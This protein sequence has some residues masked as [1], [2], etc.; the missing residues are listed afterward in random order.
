MCNF[1]TSTDF[2]I[3]NS[4]LACIRNSLESR[5]KEVIIP[6]YLTLVRLH[7]EY[8]VHFWAPHY[9]KDIAL[10]ERVQSRATRLV[11]I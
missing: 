10:L 11:G 9:K 3:D 7:L 5:S 4:I 2:Y 8:C 1:L 6:L